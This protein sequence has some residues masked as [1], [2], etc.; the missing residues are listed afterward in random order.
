MPDTKKTKIICQYCKKPY[1]AYKKGRT[2]C[3]DLN[4]RSKEINSQLDDLEYFI[5]LFCKDKIEAT[6]ELRF[7]GNDKLSKDAKINSV[8]YLGNDAPPFLDILTNGISPRELIN[9]F[10][11][12]LWKGVKGNFRI[13]TLRSGT[14]SFEISNETFTKIANPVIVGNNLIIKGGNVNDNHKR[15]S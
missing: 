14:I 8:S 2:H 5:G 4:C 6:I 7:P 3:R 12:I 13:Q 15:Q 10:R 1:T 9:Y 11:P